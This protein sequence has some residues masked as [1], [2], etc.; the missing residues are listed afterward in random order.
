M[1]QKGQA[2]IFLLVGIL[3]I[4]ALGGAYY[5]GRQTTPKVTSSIQPT[6]NPADASPAPTGAGV[7]G[8]PNGAAETAN[9]ETYTNTKYSFEFKYPPTWSVIESKAPINPYLAFIELGPTDSI[10]SGGMIAIT[11]RNQTENNYRAVLT[12]EGFQI[13]QRIDIQLG[14]NKAS[15]YKLNKTL[16]SGEKS[17]QEIVISMKNGVLYEINGGSNLREQNK[18]IFDQILF[19]FKFLP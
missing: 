6:L 16:E 18:N 1:N 12:K 3:I 8:A 7:S 17:E 10:Q 13:V 9:W 19:T 14:T 11:V 5:L 2:L 4:A 15:H